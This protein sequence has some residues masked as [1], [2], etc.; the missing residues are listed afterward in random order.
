MLEQ[1]DTIFYQND[2]LQLQN[3]SMR[4]HR[5]TNK[6]LV[7]SKVYVLVLLCHSKF[8]VVLLE[9][10]RQKIQCEEWKEKRRIRS[11]IRKFCVSVGPLKRKEEGRS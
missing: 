3:Y 2:M 7:H 9:H 4:I 6:W 5:H 8:V 11:V 10:F 1:Q